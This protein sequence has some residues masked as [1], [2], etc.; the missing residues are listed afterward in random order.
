MLKVWGA[1]WDE[2]KIYVIHEPVTTKLSIKDG[3][4]D[5]TWSPTESLNYDEEIEKLRDPSS[6]K[7]SA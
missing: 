1:F 5:F 4:P 2:R 7:L 6:I 3:L